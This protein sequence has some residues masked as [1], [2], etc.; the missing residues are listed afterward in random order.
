MYIPF[1]YTYIPLYPTYIPKKVYRTKLPHQLSREGAPGVSR[2]QGYLGEEV[3][4]WKGQSSEESEE[5]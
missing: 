1:Y 4:E 3:A 2:P 5:K